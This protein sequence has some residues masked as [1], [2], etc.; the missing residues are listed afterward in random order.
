MILSRVILG[1][2]TSAA[3]PSAISLIN[4]KYA[5]AKIAVPGKVLGI[6]AITSQVSVVLGPTLGG[7]LTQAFGW[8][9]ILF[10]N[11][12]WVIAGLFL[13]RA[14]PDY[15]PVKKSSNI[16]LFKRLDVIGIFLFSLFLLSLL[17]LLLQVTFSWY[18][19]SGVIVF[20]SLT[21][22]WE[23]RQ[24]SPFID[25]K[26]LYYKP[27]LGLVYIRTMATNYI[28][29]LLLY[30]LPQWLQG[31][32]HIAPAHAGL[33]L[34]PMTVMA[35]TMG[36]VI[37]KIEKPV[38][39]NVLGVL[40]MIVACLGLFI[41]NAHTSTPMFIGCTIVVG[42]ADGINMIANQSLLNTEA[43]LAQKGVSFGLYRT[44][45]YIGAIASGTQLKKLFHTGVTDASFHQIGFYALGSGVLLLI[46]LIP[47]VIR[48]KNVTLT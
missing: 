36:Y 23:W 17:F 45:G 16:S 12:P 19:A 32:K 42:L 10:I 43:P 5:E 14:I 46:L 8:R 2:G 22:G 47:L 48:K 39:Q 26:L 41:L 7:L 44:A 21:I 6:V 13:S 35:I 40:V 30:A 3:Y 24:G 11:I 9:G 34:L 1:L 33:T 28:L 27:A 18:Y 25:V 31:V 37:S 29:Y 38:L 20:I 15:P 4:K